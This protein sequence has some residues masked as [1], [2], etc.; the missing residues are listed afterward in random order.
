MLPDA[1]EELRLVRPAG[2]ILVE[3]PGHIF[4]GPGEGMNTVR[5]GV[6]MVAREHVLRHFPVLLGD[7]VHV[8][9]QAERQERHVQ[10]VFAR[11]VLEHVEGNDLSEHLLH[12]GVGELVMARLDG[13]VGREHAEVPHA[14]DVPHR[15]FI[16][17][18]FDVA[19]ETEEQFEGEEARMPLVQ[20]ILL[21]VEFEGLE[22]ANA[23][24]AE[25]HLLLDAVD[26]VAAVELVGDAPVLCRVLLEVGVQEE[27]RHFAARRAYHPVEPGLDVNVAAFDL[28]PDFLRH[29]RHVLGGVPDHGF[30]P[31]PAVGVDILGKISLAGYK[32]NGDQGQVQ[33]GRGLDGVAG[34]DPEAAAVGGD[35]VLHADLHGKIGDHGFGVNSCRSFII[36]PSTKRFSGFGKPI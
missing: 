35:I 17:D 6:D 9:A 3:Q 27:N 4:A 28:N 19:L 34:Q 33:I 29:E 12:D 11:N 14:G 23:S 18:A 20:M 21:D 15:P 36:L 26:A 16:P 2:N 24:H 1:D 32:G 5:N 7:A 10:A 8:L 30:F 31:L 22:H 25:D 13:G